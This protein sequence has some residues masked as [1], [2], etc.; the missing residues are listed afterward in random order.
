M[1]DLGISYSA[2]VDRVAAALRDIG[3]SLLDDPAYRPHILEPLEIIGVDAL[4][5]GHVTLKARIKTVPLKQWD[6]GRELRRRI[7][8]EFRERDIEI[9]MAQRTVWIREAPRD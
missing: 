2:D 6:V 9:P 3:Q 1:L 8:R 4:A 5:E 7:L